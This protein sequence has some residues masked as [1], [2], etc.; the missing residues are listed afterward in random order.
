M[1][2]YLLQCT[3]VVLELPFITLTLCFVFFPTPPPLHHFLFTDLLQMYLKMFCIQSEPGNQFKCFWN[4]LVKLDA[5]GFPCSSLNLCLHPI[6]DRE[7]WMKRTESRRALARPGHSSS[8][9]P[10][11]IHPFLLLQSLRICD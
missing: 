9:S 5:Q 2:C 3:E 7:T 4:W 6:L 1:P 8:S 11:N 10:V